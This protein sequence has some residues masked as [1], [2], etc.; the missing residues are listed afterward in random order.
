MAFG[1]RRGPRAGL[2]RS[3][4]PRPQFGFLPWLAFFLARSLRLLVRFDTVRRC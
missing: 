3:G 1:G 2:D 4:Q